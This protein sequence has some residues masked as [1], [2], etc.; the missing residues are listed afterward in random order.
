MGL[1]NGGGAVRGNGTL[2][3]FGDC[4]GFA[5][6]RREQYYC[7]CVHDVLHSERYRMGGDQRNV[8]IE[9]PRVVAAGAFFQSY[10]V[11]V[12]IERGAGFVE[13]DVSV[14]AYSKYLDVYRMRRGE[15]GVFVR[16]FLQILGESVGHV[17]VFRFDVDVVEHSGC[18]TGRPTYS[19]R[20]MLVM[21]L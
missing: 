11:G 21:F 1:E 10:D 13:S 15:S 7:F 4:V 3:H 9:E 8:V 5:R 18:V 16:R 14:S 19:S 20:F 12:G 6:A 17:G 2:Y